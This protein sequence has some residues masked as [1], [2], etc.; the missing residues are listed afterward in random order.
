MYIVLLGIAQE[1]FSE[2]YIKQNKQTFP[3]NVVPLS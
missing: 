3:Q 1:I 2:D